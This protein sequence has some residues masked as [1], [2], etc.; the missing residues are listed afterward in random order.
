MSSYKESGV[1][2]SKMKDIQGE[3]VYLGQLEEK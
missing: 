2:I 1:D 3:Y